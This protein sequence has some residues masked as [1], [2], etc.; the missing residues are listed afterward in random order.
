MIPVGPTVWASVLINGYGSREAWLSADTPV[1]RSSLGQTDGSETLVQVDEACFD[2][3]LSQ[4]RPLLSTIA[5]HVG[6]LICVQ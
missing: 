4:R 6:V 1:V 5:M 2:K 3:A